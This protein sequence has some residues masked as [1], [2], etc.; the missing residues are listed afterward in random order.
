MLKEAVGHGHERTRQQETH[1]AELKACAI[2]LLHHCLDMLFPRLGALLGRQLLGRRL[3]QFHSLPRERLI[4]V[5]QGDI[6]IPALQERVLDGDEHAIL[7]VAVEQ[8]LGHQGALA[9]LL[10]E[11]PLLAAVCKCTRHRRT[12]CVLPME[13]AHG[14]KLQVQHLMDKIGVFLLA[15]HAAQLHPISACPRSLELIKPQLLSSSGLLLDPTGHLLVIR[16]IVDVLALR[17]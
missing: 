13:I 5:L 1:I 14:H 4:D 12:R 10:L 15:A 3:P 9:C 11:V 2:Q 7:V 8:A 17:N 16:G 6:R